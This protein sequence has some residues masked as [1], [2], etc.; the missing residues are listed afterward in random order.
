MKKNIQNPA[1]AEGAPKLYHAGT[2][3]Y[4]KPALAILFFWL[5]WGDFC[6]TVMESVT[7]PIMQLKFKALEASNTEI[8]LIL[9]TIPGIVYCTLNPIISFKSDRYRSRWGRRIP[10][11]LFS[12]PFIVMALMGLAYGDRL[13]FWLHAH[14]GILQKVSANHVAMLTLGV[15]LVTFIFF[16]TFVTTTFWYL[17][18]DV[19]PEHLL[20]RFM[21]WFRL[22]GLGSSAL[23]LNFIFPYSD[24]H[25][26]QIFIGAA[27]LYLGGFGLMILNVREGQ[28]PPAPPYIGGQTGPVA[29][30]MT[31]GK[32]CHS[33]V[34]YWYFWALTFIGSIGGGAA[35]FNLFF[36]Q[37]VGLDLFQI[38]RIQMTASIVTA[39]L[40][41]GAGWLADRYHPIR[42]VIAATI[43]GLF[44]TPI[45]L[46]WLFWHPSAGAVWTWQA[47]WLQSVPLIHIQHWHLH[48]THLGPLIQIRQVYL[49]QFCITVGLAAP[50]AALSAMWDPVL[51]MR[52]FPQERL[53]QFCS[54][55]AVWRS[56]GS[57]LGA[58]LAGAAL[59]F[60]GR[61]V[62]VDRAYFY[63]PIWQLAFGIPAF[64]LLLKM[65]RSWKRY[66]G[67]DTYVAPQLKE[68]AGATIPANPV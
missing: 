59:D 60:V 49:V 46:I 51:L 36:L 26:T 28:Y 12:L 23:Y 56:A 25:S 21:S 66:G 11:I 43:M 47:H 57:I 13:G 39:V 58:T 3:A 53:G 44:V 35:V 22:L 42:V 17:F 52:I 38:G 8:G 1:R 14:I 34:H 16:N 20:A 37:R 55:N 19:V 29:A 48:M 61:R 54:T 33:H 32:E 65:Y 67:D 40:V 4:T 45:N 10:F 2:L 27:V 50:V 18:R 5:L 24:T 30:I 6:Y 31:Y 68:S 7:N 62:G 9:G 63:I 15:L 41:L 64:I